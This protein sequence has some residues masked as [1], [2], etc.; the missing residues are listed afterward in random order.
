MALFKK[1]HADGY[2]FDVIIVGSGVAGAIAAWKLAT[3]DDYRI[4]ILEAGDNG[5]NE[6]QRVEFHHAMDR[7]GNRGD[8]FAP[9]LELASRTM[10]PSP[11]KAAA[12]KPGPGLPFAEKY[13]DYSRDARHL[14]G[15][16]HPARRRKYVGLARESVHASCPPTSD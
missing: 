5:I 6:G 13:Y 7:Q 9:Y 16:L 3:Y 10:V 15:R 12:P 4:L 11:E 14:P 8:M 1:D 2:D